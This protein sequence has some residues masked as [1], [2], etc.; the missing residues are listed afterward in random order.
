MER[1]NKAKR[2]NQQS[3]KRKRTGG[4]RGDE[5]G[6]DED[7]GDEDWA[8]ELARDLKHILVVRSDAGDWQVLIQVEEWDCLDENWFL[9]D[10]TWHDHDAQGYR[11]QNDDAFNR[12]PKEDRKTPFKVRFHV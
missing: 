1:L 10:S 9:V 12:Y 8:A 2:P 5:S 11:I 3:L 7:W 6:G 4:N